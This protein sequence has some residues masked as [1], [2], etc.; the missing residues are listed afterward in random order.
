MYSPFTPRDTQ[1]SLLQGR[2][3]SRYLYP[4]LLL[5]L[6]LCNP[7][8]QAQNQRADR[9]PRLVLQLVMGSVSANQVRSIWEELT[10]N[11]FNRIE[12][13]GVKVENVL[14][15]QLH[16]NGVSGCASI[17]CGATGATHGM[18]GPHWF[19]TLTNQRVQAVEDNDYIAVGAAGRGRKC[20]PKQIPV[21]T[22][23]EAWRAAYPTSR[24]Y[25]AALEP[26]EAIILGG[27]A[28]NAALWLDMNSG[29]FV[30]S[31]YYCANPPK[32]VAQ[33]NSKA[34]PTAYASRAEADR[35]SKIKLPGAKCKRLT[36]CSQGNS[37]LKDLIVSAIAG[38]SLGMREKA[39]PDLLSVYFTGFEGIN[40]LYGPESPQALEA[41][42]RFDRE[43][44]DL[45]D[46]LSSNVGSQH[47]LIILT[48]AFSAQPS[49]E[50]YSQWH[51]PSGHF[52]M[53]RALFLLNSYLRAVYARERLAMGCSAGQIYLDVSQLEAGLTSVESV[54]RKAAQMLRQMEGV[55]A[56]FTA[57]AL[58]NGQGSG[59]LFTRT[60]Q[61][62]NW[63]RSGNL[64]IELQ[65]G[66]LFS[67]SLSNQAVG[68]ETSLDP[69]PIPLYFYGWKLHRA[70]VATPTSLADIL[71]SLCALMQ[72]AQPHSATGST[73][74]HVVSW[75]L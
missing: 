7:T 15:N 33:F 45:L 65:P 12:E 64:L 16:N 36:A 30:T 37:L 58:E 44:S 19:S 25:S 11:G 18:I 48:S 46:F 47:Y 32:W 23:S 13:Q 2:G 10:P 22:L 60:V 5:L 52:S 40:T 24:I 9:P 43:L 27:R 61:G 49:S 50:Y 26:E 28:A 75:E 73:I 14:Q 39:Q 62:Y 56:I 4:A 34:L 1:Q 59:P 66:W 55:Q 57:S 3:Y 8:L 63:K 21:L 17:V 72:I 53:E 35:Y 74:E 70:R 42:K 20:S 38:D 31:S 69:G 67:S 51:L 6:L 29:N 41:L 68:S 54:E 71:P